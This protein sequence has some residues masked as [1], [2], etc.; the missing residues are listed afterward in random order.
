MESYYNFYDIEYDSVISGEE[1]AH[2]GIIG[3]IES[4][5]DSPGTPV[6]ITLLGESHPDRL[7]S[8][9]GSLYGSEAGDGS[10]IPV[11]IIAGRTNSITGFLTA[12]YI[13][14]DGNAGI[15][16]GDFSGEYYDSIN[17]WI[18]EGAITATQMASGY[19]SEDYDYDYNYYDG[20]L[21]QGG[22]DA[23]G[24]IFYAEGK[25]EIR[26]ISNGSCASYTAWLIDQD[27]MPEGWGIFNTE[28]GGYFD[29]E[30][31]DNWY[32]SFAGNEWTG[33]YEEEF[34]MGTI[35]G[36][37]WTEDGE[38]S[39]NARGYLFHTSDD[40]E[41]MLTMGTFS[42][43]VTGSYGIEGEPTVFEGIAA[44]E[45]VELAELEM[46]VLGFDMETLN[47][48]VSIPITEINSGIL[49]GAGNFTAGGAITGAVMD[50]SFYSNEFADLWAAYFTGNYSDPT[51]DDFT[52]DLTNGDISA[53]LTGESWEDNQWLA[54]VDGR[55]PDGMTFTGQAG[56]T[57]TDDGTFTGVGAGTLTQPGSELE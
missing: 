18:A 44:G 31:S 40:D 9:W 12:L 32:L 7:M 39:G 34:W 3:A 29:G 42:G 35:D 28:L 14:T 46:D 20:L 56:G 15:L 47:D 17:Q 43:K 10:S 21:S 48:F 26:D 1:N 51:G 5:F 37:L 54:G 57:Y 50:V 16:N 23:G 22:F 53:T 55:G 6:N 30:T 25:D 11:G 27:D 36:T 8:W 2:M 52:I 49:T 4:P 45:W 13:D 19:T 38:L 24:N 41:D 33:L